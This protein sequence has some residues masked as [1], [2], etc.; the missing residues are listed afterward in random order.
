MKIKLSLSRQMLHSWRNLLR[1]Y[2]VRLVNA[3]MV[4]AA[5]GVLM[6][7]IFF[8]TLMGFFRLPQNRVK[9]VVPASFFQLLN[10]TGAAAVVL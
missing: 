6:A 2:A 5:A 4:P 7:A 8:G 1:S 9:D 3:S 10:V